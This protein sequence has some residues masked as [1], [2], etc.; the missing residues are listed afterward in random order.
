MRKATR[1]RSGYETHYYWYVFN[2][3]GNPESWKRHIQTSVPLSSRRIRSKMQLREKY[4]VIGCYISFIVNEI[5]RQQ[6]LVADQPGNHRRSKHI[7]T[8]IYFVRDGVLNGDVQLI[9]I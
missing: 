2:I 6:F 7:N 1:E 9:Y 8:R 5:I 4:E 3:S